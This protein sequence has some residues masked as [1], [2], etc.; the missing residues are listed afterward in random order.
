MQIL[1]KLYAWYIENVG[2]LMADHAKFL[3]TMI[4]LAVFEP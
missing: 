1:Y 3:P 4:S 2:S